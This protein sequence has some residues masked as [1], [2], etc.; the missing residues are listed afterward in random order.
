MALV[1]IPPANAIF[2]NDKGNHWASTCLY[3]QKDAIYQEPQRKTYIQIYF[4]LTGLFFFLV[5]ITDKQ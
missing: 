3:L 4:Y 5:S 2:N 1:K